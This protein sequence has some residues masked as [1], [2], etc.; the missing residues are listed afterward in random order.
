MPNISLRTLFPS[1]LLGFLLTACNP[2]YIVTFTHGVTGESIDPGPYMGCWEFVGFFGQDRQG[3]TSLAARVGS[4][5]NLVIEMLDRS[6]PSEPEIIPAELSR[7][8]GMILLSVHPKKEIEALFEGYERVFILKISL[9][10]GGQQLVAH[11]TDFHILRHDIRAGL[12]TGEIRQLDVEDDTIT[13]QADGATLAAYFRANPGVFV[14]P[15]A[16][17]SKAPDAGPCAPSNGKQEPLQEPAPT[18]RTAE[19]LR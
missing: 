2:A 15:V 12:V 18:E 10:N 17:L 1:L 9:E 3:N 8:G 7:V 6:K 13:V 4:D 5:G 14:A 19:V 11:G 16:V